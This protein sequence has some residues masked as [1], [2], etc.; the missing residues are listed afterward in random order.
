[1]VI[2]KDITPI[3]STQSQK[4][5]R[6]WQQ[7]LT[8]HFSAA[9][10]TAHYSPMVFGVYNKWGKKDDG[11]S[12]WMTRTFG[13]APILMSNVNP[14]LRASVAKSVLQ[15]NGYFNGD[16]TYNTKDYGKRDSLGLAKKQKI[17]YHV[18]FGHLYTLDSISFSNFPT[19]I[20][21]RIFMGDKKRRQ[22]IK[23]ETWGPI[24]DCQ[25]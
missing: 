11:F 7:R 18:N 15:N 16:I 5:R 2:R 23:S 10:I 6:H 25:S 12:K 21:Q 9:V 13:K 4:W 24:L 19:D 20:Y 17:Q 3:Y 22:H 8:E 14:L 1:M